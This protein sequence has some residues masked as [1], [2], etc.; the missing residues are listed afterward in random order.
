MSHLE[1]LGVPTGGV[2]NP[3]PMGMMR[4]GISV[5]TVR[6]EGSMVAQADR[7]G[8]DDAA[9]RE[10]GKF[11]VREPKTGGEPESPVDAYAA[12]ELIRRHERTE[13]MIRRAREQFA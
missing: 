4:C 5:V 10:A 6:T 2:G 13:S 8:T 1:H 11:A 7:T 9:V 12:S 3:A